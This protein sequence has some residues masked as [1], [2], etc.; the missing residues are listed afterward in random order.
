MAIAITNVQ[1]DSGDQVSVEITGNLVLT[2][3]YGPG[4][5]GHGDIINWSAIPQ[6]P[7]NAIPIFVDILEAPAAG[8]APNGYIFQFCPGTTP[9]N[10]VITVFNNLNE[11]TPNSA[12]NAGLL[13]AVIKFRAIFPM[14][15]GEPYSMV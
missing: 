6:I 10:G 14:F 1:V 7:S 15:V 12:Y 13:A 2:G 11:Y 8:T 5:T 9:A 3:N 4:I